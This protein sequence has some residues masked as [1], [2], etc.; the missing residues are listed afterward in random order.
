M[1]AIIINIDNYINLNRRVVFF[2]KNTPTKIILDIEYY[3]YALIKNGHYKSMN[4]L[5]FYNDKKYY[6]SDD[7]SNILRN[8]SDLSN[9]GIS[10]KFGDKYELDDTIFELMEK[11]DEYYL[12]SFTLS[13]IVNKDIIDDILKTFTEKYLNITNFFTFKPNTKRD[14][15]S[16]QFERIILKLLYGVTYNKSVNVNKSICSEYYICDN[17]MVLNSFNW[18]ILVRNLYKK[19]DSDD[20]NTLVENLKTNILYYILTTNNDFNKIK[21]INKIDVQYPTSSIINHVK[22]FEQFSFDLKKYL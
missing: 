4:N 1:K 11:Y 14:I 17:D 22:T 7:I 3:E 13:D 6:L 2:N 8:K 9:L 18:S 19:L 15:L 5:I 12:Y 21:E 20:K 16:S 10:V